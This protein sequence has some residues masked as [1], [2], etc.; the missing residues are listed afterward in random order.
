MTDRCS[1]IYCEDSS[2]K[3]V[4]VRSHRRLKNGRLELVHAYYR[5]KWG[6]KKLY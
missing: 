1:V 2:N 5:A 6:S 3:S 4:P